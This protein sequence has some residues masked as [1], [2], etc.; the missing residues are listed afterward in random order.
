MAATLPIPRVA[1]VNRS[2]AGW[3]PAQLKAMAL[4][5]R[6]NRRGLMRAGCDPARIAQYVARRTRIP[7]RDIEQLLAAAESEARSTR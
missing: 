6:L 3:C 7:V 2:A 1:P 5:P 4:W